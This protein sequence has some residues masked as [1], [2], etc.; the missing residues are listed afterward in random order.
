MIASHT[1]STTTRDASATVYCVHSLSSFRGCVESAEIYVSAVAWNSLTF[2][3]TLCCICF[4][5]FFFS[6]SAVTYIKLTFSINTHFCL[7][8][9]KNQKRSL[10]DHKEYVG[11]IPSKMKVQTWT[12]GML[13]FSVWPGGIHNNVM[14]L[15]HHTSSLNWFLIQPSIDLYRRKGVCFEKCFF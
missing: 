8:L 14:R 7:D 9:W 6:K 15:T 5:H 11:K 2:V 10:K 1:A 13:N 12:L 4:Y 3:A